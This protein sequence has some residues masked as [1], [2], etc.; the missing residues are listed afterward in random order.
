MQEIKLVLQE[1]TFFLIK[2]MMVT[3]YAMPVVSEDSTG[4]DLPLFYPPTTS[5]FPTSTSKPK[6]NIIKT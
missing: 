1:K 6:K 4:Q 2:T 5:L 3:I